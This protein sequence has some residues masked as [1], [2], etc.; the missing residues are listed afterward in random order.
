MFERVVCES[1]VCERGVCDNILRARERER[2]RESQS[3][4]QG[5]SQRVVCVCANVVCVSHLKRCKTSTSDFTCSFF[6]LLLA[7][8]KMLNFYP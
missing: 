8:E 3:Q 7:R 6:V 2:E 1:A 5:Q 4:S